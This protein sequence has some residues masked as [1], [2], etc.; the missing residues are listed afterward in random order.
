MRPQA[1]VVL[2]LLVACTAAANAE[3]LLTNSNFDVDVSGWF[4]FNESTRLERC[5]LDVDGLLNSGSECLTN[6]GNSFASVIQCVA[7]VEGT[8]YRLAAWA[9]IPADH[10]VKGKTEVGPT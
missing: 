1:T 4:E 7:T 3:N 5:A 2:M 6:V 8:R 9:Y 10:A